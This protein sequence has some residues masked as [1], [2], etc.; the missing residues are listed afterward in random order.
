MGIAWQV[1]WALFGDYGLPHEAAH[2]LHYLKPEHGLSVRR[3]QERFVD[4]EF[5]HRELFA[6]ACETY[7]RVVLHGPILL[8]MP[9]NSTG[10]AISFSAPRRFLAI[11]GRRSCWRSLA[12]SRNVRRS[13]AAWSSLRNPW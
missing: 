13:D 11:V 9:R 6:Y 3:G 4:I 5:C 8:P 7:S 1:L 2:L 10:F 12:S